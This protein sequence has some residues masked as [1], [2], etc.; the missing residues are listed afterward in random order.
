MNAI[1]DYTFF[2]FDQQY[3]VPANQRADTG[4]A[5]SKDMN[6]YGCSLNEYYA[7]INNYDFFK[8]FN[9]TW[10]AYEQRAN[11]DSAVARDL[12]STACTST[13]MYDITT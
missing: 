2:D 12:A 13:K 8:F 10:E 5:I 11:T 9:T 3:F 4:G 6:I 7:S 1:P